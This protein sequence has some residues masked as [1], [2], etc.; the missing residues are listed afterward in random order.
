M[1]SISSR[2][3]SMDRIE[4]KESEYNACIEERN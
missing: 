3:S 1:M 4:E 2:S